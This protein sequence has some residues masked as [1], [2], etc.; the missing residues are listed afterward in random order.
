M[1]QI[2]IKLCQKNMKDLIYTFLK[3][4]EFNFKTDSGSFS[5]YSVFLNDKKIFIDTYTFTDFE[6]NFYYRVRI[7]INYSNNH[8]EKKE[9]KF[10]TSSKSQCLQFVKDVIISEVE[11]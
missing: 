10:I 7:K 3:K 8:F 11:E 4:N 6:L 1:T 9:F 5:G 2:Y